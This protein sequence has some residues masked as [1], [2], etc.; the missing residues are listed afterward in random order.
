[1]G[2]LS[3]LTKGGKPRRNGIIKLAR[4]VK[5]QHPNWTNAQAFNHAGIIWQEKHLA[6]IRAAQ[7]TQ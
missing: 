7:T 2:K 1:M 4:E 5:A 6:A 3:T